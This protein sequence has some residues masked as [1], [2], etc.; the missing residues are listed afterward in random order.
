[1]FT[2]PVRRLV[3]VSRGLH[4]RFCFTNT[5]VDDGE[6]LIGLQTGTA[7]QNTVD[8]VLTQKRGCIP[9]FNAA[10]VMDR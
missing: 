6:K 1:M 4:F 10:T 5:R 2:E 7:N 9:R 3:R 8:A